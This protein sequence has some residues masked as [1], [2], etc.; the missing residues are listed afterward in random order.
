MSNGPVLRSR[1]GDA[2][3]TPP[4][5]KGPGTHRDIVWVQRG[6]FLGWACSQCA[7]EFK[8]SGF[9]EGDTIDEMK[10]AFERKRDT[11]FESHVCAKHPKSK[12]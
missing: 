11:E 12:G 4:S 10:D 2:V 6:T 9:P 7:W 1:L 8:P 3:G 5:R